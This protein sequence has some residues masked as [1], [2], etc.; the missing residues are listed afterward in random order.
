MKF[1][2]RF[3]ILT[4]MACILARPALARLSIGDIGDFVSFK[5]LPVWAAASTFYNSDWD[6]WYDYD[7]R[8]LTQLVAT[9][10]AKSTVVDGIKEHVHAVRPNKLDD[11]SFPSGHTAN[12]FAQAAFI[13][14][15]YG[16]C[17]A[18]APYALAAFVGYSRVQAKMHYVHDV[19]AGAAIGFLSA[20]IFTTPRQSL[21][22][23]VDG[24]G[25]RVDFNIK[26]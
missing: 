1:L 8:G 14:R 5:I 2:G 7:W 22:I 24:D 15:R 17:Q 6:T 16:I 12:A 10:L 18:I 21:M 3:V 13:H 11:N 26:F 4:V 23:S 9:N 25:A 20:W 19:L